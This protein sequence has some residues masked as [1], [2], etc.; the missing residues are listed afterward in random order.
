MTILGATVLRRLSTYTR[1]FKL[2]VAY[3]A[4]T[5]ME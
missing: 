3:M 1:P 5:G 2:E 4:L